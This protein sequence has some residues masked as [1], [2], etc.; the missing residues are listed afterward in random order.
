VPSITGL[1]GGVFSFEQTPSDITSIDANIGGLM[2]YTPGNSYYIRYTTN[3]TCPRFSIDTVTVFVNPLLPISNLDSIQ[4]GESAISIAI[5][6]PQGG[7]INWYSDSL[8]TNLIYSGSPIVY[9]PTSEIYVTETVNG[10]TSDPKRITIYELS[11]SF[12]TSAFTPNNDNINDLWV[13]EG[14]DTMCPNNIVKVFNRWG[15]II[16]ESEKGKYEENSWDGLINGKEV[17][18]GSY[19]YNIICNDSEGTTFT[20]T[21]SIIR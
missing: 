21:V 16:F 6:N 12:Y 20:G 19:Y 7:V 2:N 13:L 18:T 9:T 17:P 8:L 3:G 15:D 1:T 4:S 14:I 10:C 11:S 5:S